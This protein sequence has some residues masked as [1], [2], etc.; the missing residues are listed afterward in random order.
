MAAAADA[1]DRDARAGGRT[2]VAAA[3]AAAAAETS[4]RR[5]PLVA[6]SPPCA[7]ALPIAAISQT[8]S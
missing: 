3:A 7:L 2:A 4:G 6:A 1:A 5:V 8:D